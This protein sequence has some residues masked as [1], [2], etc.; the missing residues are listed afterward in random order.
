MV[1]VATDLFLGIMKLVFF[2]MLF[3]LFIGLI[4][5]LIKGVI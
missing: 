4:I 2:A 5:K 3:L 1:E